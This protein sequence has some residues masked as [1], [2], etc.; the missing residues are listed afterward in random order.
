GLDFD[1]FSGQISLSDISYCAEEN[2]YYLNHFDLKATQGDD[3]SMSLN[4]DIVNAQ[5][6]GDF[7]FS[8]LG[9]S[10]L[11]IASKI[12]PSLDPPIRAHSD[13]AFNIEI[14]VNDFDQI[15]EVFIPGLSI[16]T[17]TIVKMEIDEASSQLD[18]LVATDSIRFQEECVYGLTLSAN[19]PDESFYISASLDTMSIAGVSL[20]QIS[21]DTRTVGDSIYTSFAWQNS[22]EKHFGDI[23]GKLIVNNYQDMQ[24][25]VYPSSIGALNKSWFISKNAK[26]GYDGGEVFVSNFSI[27][28][29]DQRIIID[30]MVS[31]SPEAELSVKAEKFNLDNLNFMMDDSLSLRGQ[32]FGE[33]TLRNLFHDPILTGDLKAVG[34]G[35]NEYE[36]GDIETHTSWDSKRE[37][38]RL[39]GS[40]K[41]V[42]MLKG[43][44]NETVPLTFA[45]YYM[46]NEE[47]QLD[48]S[49]TLQHMDLSVVNTF[50]PKETMDIHGF[51][52]GT[53][54]IDGPI[55]APQ[56]HSTIA[57]QDGSLYVHYLN[58]TYFIHDKIKISPD[59]VSFDNILITDEE[60]HRGRLTGQILHENFTRWNFDIITD[61]SEPMLAMNTDESMNDMYFGKAYATGSINISGDEEDME[62]DINV[63][64]EKGTTLALPMGNSTEE[65][66]ESF[67]HFINPKDS[68]AKRS[69]MD[70][71]G[72]NMRFGI[73]VTP[74]AEFQVIFD[75]SIGDVITGRGTGHLEMKIDELSNF[76]MAGEVEVKSGTYLFTLKNLISKNLILKPGGKIEWISDPFDAQLDLTAV[77]EVGVSLYDLLPEPQYQSGPKVNTK[78]DMNLKGQLFSPAIDFKIDLPT[79]DQVT[80]SRVNAAISSEQEKNRQAF[81]LLVL[82]RFVSP[83]N[84][85]VDHNS[86]NAIAANGM[87]F[88]SSQI[89]N[90]L[91]QISDDV[92][93]G[94]NYN[95]GDDIS[96]EEIKLILSTQLFNER[97][98]ISSN[99]GVS[100]NN[101]NANAQNTNNLIGD[102][103]IEYKVTKEGRVRVVMY[104][105]SND[106][107]VASTQQSPYTQGLGV[108]YREEFD[109]I[110]EFVHNLGEMLRGEKKNADSTP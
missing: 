90:W 78:L 34:L 41:Q 69:E 104:N 17:G 16:A 68:I 81:A 35:L 75:K 9:S 39:D 96:N 6:V 11:E 4:S 73:D 49:A 46:P 72:I 37:R 101:N 36:L 86:S 99:L 85:T 22:R 88:V 33:I 44:K 89:S 94:F 66:F 25:E 3:P 50:L 67:I 1:R 29:H 2:D 14:R 54:S 65:T 21:L 71:S 7:S 63:K 31:E 28:H 61:L 45:G 110:N 32:V 84:V 91:S 62:F 97:L 5:L 109:N 38:L 18:L 106:Y 57:L 79:V 12:I 53:I 13:Q 77:Y 47:N 93:L 20:N 55:D 107:R 105:E 27:A 24:F 64:T 95:P 52:T 59:M 82:R 80:K 10:M 8:E 70:F 51:A 56:L 76:T 43:S 92:N 74:D 40:V 87:E 42:A 100:R 15:S 26:I 103:R 60:N 19:Q 30:G 83:P 23:S 58:T 48:L 102:I 108:I 98:S